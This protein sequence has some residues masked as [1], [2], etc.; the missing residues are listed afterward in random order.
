MLNININW[1]I[2][3]VS[4]LSWVLRS[5]TERVGSTTLDMLHISLECHNVDYPAPPDLSSHWPRQT[6]SVQKRLNQQLR[7]HKSNS[8][9]EC[10]GARR[11]VRSDP[12]LPVL[13]PSKWDSPGLSLESRAQRGVRK[14]SREQGIRGHGSREKVPGMPTPSA[15]TGGDALANHPGHLRD[16][17]P[18]SSRDAEA[19]L[20][21][22]FRVSINNSGQPPQSLPMVRN[23]LISF[24]SLAEIRL[25]LPCPI[26]GCFLSAYVCMYVWSWVFVFWWP[27]H[28]RAY[29][30]NFSIN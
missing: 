29:L 4:Y 2:C 14:K 21:A 5:C 19:H 11:A 13:L 8:R 16:S 26:S 22:R 18:C 17:A 3:Q 1:E 6:G 23:S 24:R 15:V 9:V 27:R 25:W 30:N 10:R 20:P 12:G 7:E 28:S